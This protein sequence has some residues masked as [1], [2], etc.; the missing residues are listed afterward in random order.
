LVYAD[1]VNLMGENIV[2]M[3]KKTE[4]V[5]DTSKEVSLEVNPEKTKHMLMSHYQKVGPKRSIRLPN[6]FFEDMEKFKYLGTTLTDQSCMH[7]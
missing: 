6:R 3:K 2:T 4:T 7:E 5:L 1:D